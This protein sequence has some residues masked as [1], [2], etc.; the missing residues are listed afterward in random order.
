MPAV[1]RERRHAAESGA[2]QRWQALLV[3]DERAFDGHGWSVSFALSESGWASLRLPALFRSALSSIGNR[4]HGK[5]ALFGAT[6]WLV[7]TAIHIDRWLAWP[8]RKMKIAAKT[9]KRMWAKLIDNFA[10]G[11]DEEI[12]NS[13][14]EECLKFGNRD[15]KFDVKILQSLCNTWI[16]EVGNLPWRFR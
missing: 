2:V 8:D 12:K 4:I 15:R 9:G 10:N 6:P 5:L 11:S 14:I 3:Q 13:F 16:P 1:A 7:P